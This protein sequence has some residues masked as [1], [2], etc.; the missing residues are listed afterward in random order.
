MTAPQ[1]LLRQPRRRQRRGRTH[2]QRARTA[3]RPPAAHAQLRNAR[4]ELPVDRHH[5]RQHFG[6]PELLEPQR[7][8]AGPGGR[9]LRGGCGLSAPHLHLPGILT[10]LL[11]R[12]LDRLHSAPVGRYSRGA[13]WCMFARLIFRRPIGPRCVCALLLLAYSITAAGVPISIGSS[14]QKSGEIFPCMASSCGCRSADQCWR[15]C[16]CHSLTERL[17]WARNRGIEPPAF[18]LAQARAAGLDLTLIT[19][20]GDSC[21]DESK[22]CRSDS[23]ATTTGGKDSCAVATTAFKLHRTA[24]VRTKSS[25]GVPWPAVANRRTGWPRCQHVYR[26]TWS[27]TRNPTPGLAGSGQLRCRRRRVTRSCRPAS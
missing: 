20:A 9:A 21:D 17:A 14:P 6:R 25:P 1:K 13:S 8:A 7:H 18:A 2:R 4:P 22:C 27:V 23:L 12:E 15:S 26:A 3:R 16:C 5:E 24:S 11:T 19:T 10:R